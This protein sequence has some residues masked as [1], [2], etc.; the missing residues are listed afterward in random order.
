MEDILKHVELIEAY[1]EGRLSKQEKQD[2]EAKLITDTEL[3]EELKL[4]KTLVAGIKD[5]GLEKDKNN[6]KEELKEVDNN[7]DKKSSHGTK[8]IILKRIKWYYY[9][10]ACVL[11][12]IIPLYFIVTE[13]PTEKLLSNYYEK[14]KGLPVLMSGSKNISLDNAMNLYKQEKYK[15]A[16]QAFNELLKD[17]PMN[18]TLNY[19]SALS[20]FELEKYNKAIKQFTI[21]LQN[22]TSVFKEKAEYYL[23]LTYFAVDKIQ[24]AKELFNKIAAN[25]SHRYQEKAQDIL[26]ELDK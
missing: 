4:Y 21:I 16:K 11:L 1:V 8:T 22:D 23:G 6:L 19:Y 12:L 10:A 24:Q 20:S 2:F 26:R 9:A 17:K 15:E 13:N 5:S 14:D 3:A 25:P 7:L 18:D